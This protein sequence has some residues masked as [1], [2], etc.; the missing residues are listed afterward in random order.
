V[1]SRLNIQ[2][3][4]IGRDE[5]RPALSSPYDLDRHELR[6]APVRSLNRTRNFVLLPIGRQLAGGGLIVGRVFDDGG[7]QERPS[8]R[9][10]SRLRKNTALTRPTGCESESK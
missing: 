9:G 5:P 7:V 4:G 8:V 6:L 2:S 3:P 10:K 1:S